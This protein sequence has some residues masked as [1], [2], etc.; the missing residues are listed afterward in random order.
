MRSSR[1]RFAVFALAVAG[2]GVVWL[3]LPTGAVAQQVVQLAQPAFVGEG[4]GTPKEPVIDKLTFPE[5]RDT[6]KKFEA[7]TDYLN[8][9]KNIKWKEVCELSQQLLDAK[10]DYFFQYQEGDKRRVSVKDEVNRLIGK[11]PEEG[12]KNYQL[13]WGP[14]ADG[15]LKE[16]KDGGFD[17]SK[18]A[19]VS[20]RYFHTKAGAEATLLLATLNLEAGHFAE[21]AYGYKRMLDR[22]DADKLLDP[23]TLF[24]AA[25]A[26]RRAGDG[27]MTDAVAAVW[28]KL[29]KKFPREGVQLGRKAYSLEMLK[30]DLDKPVEMLFGSVGDQFVAMKGGNATRV[31]LAEAGAP[32]LG[33]VFSEPVL[34]REDTDEQK[35]A[36]KWV[37][38]NIDMAY[39]RT[40]NKQVPPL[41]PSAFPVT[42]PNLIV[43]RGYDGVYAFYTRDFRD[44]A[45]QQRIAGSLAWHNLGKFGVAAIRGGGS[46]DGDSPSSDK[47]KQDEW[48]GNYWSQNLPSVLFENPLAGGL[49]H[50][51]KRAYFVDDFHVP[52]SNMQY[53]PEWGQ[54]MPGATAARG[55]GGK[56]EYNRL[57]AVDLDTGMLAWSLGRPSANSRA[58]ETDRIG[59]AAQLAEGAYFLG[60]PITVNGKLY[61]MLE[62]DTGLKLACFDSYKLSDP[63]APVVKPGDRPLPTTAKPSPQ[64]ELLWVQSLGRSNSPVRQ[65]A[66]R[67][68]Q[69]AFLAAADGVIVCPTNSGA[70]VA[71]DLNARSLLWAHT[72]ATDTK[73]G[74]PNE[75]L[76]MA[77]LGRG[78]M[79]PGGMQNPA[80][81]RW[82]ASGPI[83]AGNRVIVSAYD[84][85]TVNCLDLRTG[86][87]LWSEARKDTDLYVG[88]VVNDKVLI[89][90]KNEVRAVKLVGEADDKNKREKATPAWASALKI[91]TPLGHGV[92][93]KDGH[94]YVPVFGD[95]DKSDDQTPAVWAVNADS[96]KVTGKT[97]YRRK[98]AARTGPGTDPRLALGNLVFHDGMMFSQSATELV[99]FP[100]NEAKHAEMT[101]LLAKN[102]NDPDGLFSRGELSLEKGDLLK[103][104]DDFKKSQ[105]NNPP[106]ATAYKIKQKLYTAYTEIL[107]TKFA[108][109]EPFLT[110]YKALCEFPLDKDDAEYPRLRDEQIRRRG[111]YYSL[112]AEGRKGQGRLVEAFENY[113]AYA[114]LGEK[115]KLLPVPEDPNTLAL[116]GVWASGR[117]DAMMKAATDPAVR[118]PL[119]DRVAKD[120]AEVKAAN[121]L[122]RLRNFVK[123]F[124]PYFTAGRDAQ[125][126]LADRLAAT[127]NDDDR[128]E[129]Q[130]LLLT[131]IGR[132]DG[133]KDTPTVARATGELA[134]L[135]T[136]RGLLDDALGLYNRLA[137]RYPTEV[138]V[139]GKTGGELL[140][141]LITDK[142]YWP[143]LES[144]RPVTLTRYAAKADTGA[145]SSTYKQ[146]A[147]T[148]NPEGDLLPFYQRNRVSLDSDSNGSVSLVVTDRVT[149]EKK[150]PQL[151]LTERGQPAVPG[152]A[153]WGATYNNPNAS[154]SNQQFAHASGHLLLLHYERYVILYD[155]S[156]G[157][158]LWR[159]NI[160]AQSGVQAN[161]QLSAQVTQDSNT[162]PDLTVSL[163]WYNQMTGQQYTEWSW[164]VG[165][166]AVLQANYA[167]IL[168]RDGLVV[169]DPRTGTVL[170]Q[171][172]G[173]AQNALIVGDAKHVYLVEQLQNGSSSRVLRAVDGVQIQGVPE[174][175]SLLAGSSRVHASGRHVLLF[176]SGGKDKPR[177]LKLY[178]ILDGKDVWA[179]QYPADSA[180][181]DPVDP[182]L[183]GVVSADGDVEVLDART[184]KPL[185]TAKV[186]AGRAAEHLKDDKGKFAVVKPLLMADG[187]RY[188]VFLNRAYTQ[189]LVNG[190]SAESWG[191]S[192]NRVRFVNGPAYAF[193]RRT[194]KRLWY[195]STQFVNQRLLVERFDE[196]PCLVAFN[197]MYAEEGAQQP[198]GGGGMV[199]RGGGFG[200]GGAG[201]PGASHKIVVVDKASGAL[202]ENKELLA[203]QGWFQSFSYDPK[204]STYELANYQN[205]RLRITPPDDK[206]DT[207]GSAGVPKPPEPRI[208]K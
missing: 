160:A 43:F 5:N 178:D 78:G 149:G 93:G 76:R 147:M 62:T 132:A 37:K 134:K 172:A 185:L 67:R 69:G 6:S 176:E 22:Q 201:V 139:N 12:V 120:W 86:R 195:T 206:K 116:S 14:A 61:V 80:Q 11:F 133:D 123:V 129:A 23:K 64:P 16:A 50:D 148:L 207:K 158:E 205:A 113:R 17:R 52:P 85:G 197:P 162:S 7:V 117:I 103:A 79:A 107:R 71:V 105:A 161:Q 35:D 144:K 48:W 122:D 47:Q 169:K 49:S 180:V 4:P 15:L 167:A 130:A 128:R 32:F 114:E 21:A 181:F 90:G 155:L 188:Y 96:G 157:A 33:T 203:G 184:G 112:V 55:T 174:F 94:F 135:L 196:L 121:D 89:V 59:S 63:P 138:A 152:L 170:W 153:N 127:N 77:R 10:S 125:F 192:P 154:M 26:L 54:V 145:G 45:G 191:A 9:P 101:A 18:L 190:Q 177:T 28:E 187:E 194:G 82:R 106:E 146:P 75:D 51:G 100:L 199:I 42:A 137:E 84:S 87:L 102:P 189:I 73:T 25:V 179:K 202:R 30:G 27:K 150:F 118:K 95:P 108:D 29:E 60:P 141:D 186:D 58:E 175:G 168:T 200:R 74:N 31:A 66:L 151:P 183:T 143:A 204:T 126:L 1:I 165:K 193:D 53:N 115:D 124:G 19:E 156:K 56:Q 8:A 65:D 171:R 70:I 97:L 36:N 3:S 20:Q 109:G 34:R 68:I 83:I 198:Q 91:P 166:S 41:L 39:Q 88:G 99:A 163:T 136:S 2:A 164:K 104:V 40:K 92:A 13:L 208:S 24:K 72:Y 57:V 38:A 110:E 111:L 142:Q 46:D 44:A 81:N 131:L 140:G 98:D 182:T 173:V 159:V 119:E